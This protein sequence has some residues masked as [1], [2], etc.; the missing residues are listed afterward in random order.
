MSIS[1]R[2]RIIEK[3]D[4]DEDDDDELPP[5][6]WQ[7][8]ILRWM[9]IFSPETCHSP[10][11]SIDQLFTPKLVGFDGDGEGNRGP[12]GDLVGEPVAA[13][14]LDIQRNVQEFESSEEKIP[15]P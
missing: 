4:L 10:K 13:N 12:G 1:L 8:K 11:V 2:D 6:K 15:K 3:F 14:P 5:L 9:K 7:K